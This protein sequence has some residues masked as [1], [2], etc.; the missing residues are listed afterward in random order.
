MHSVV[1]MAGGF[2]ATLGVIGF[3]IT[4]PTLFASAWSAS[5]APASDTA[6]DV[7]RAAKGDRLPRPTAQQQRPTQ[8]TPGPVRTLQE[9]KRPRME[10]CDP[11]VSPLAGSSLSRVAGRCLAVVNPPERVVMAGPVPVS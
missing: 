4:G 1:T 10:G 7:N 9:D 8:P 6:P 3:A 5:L 11:L 2:V